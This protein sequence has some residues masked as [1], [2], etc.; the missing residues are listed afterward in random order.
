MGKR[1]GL[2][3]RPHGDESVNPS[4]QLMRDEAAQALEVELPVPEGR[5]E[6]GKRASKRADFHE[7]DETF[8]LM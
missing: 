8:C 3:R 6:R 4:P 7:D 1:R 5:G 2:S